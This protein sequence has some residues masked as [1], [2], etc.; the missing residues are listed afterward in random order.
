M[1]W[2]FLPFIVTDR[3]LLPSHPYYHYEYENQRYAFDFIMLKNGQAF[4]GDSLI[5]ES[6][7]AFGGP[8]LAPCA[9]TVIRVENTNSDNLDEHRAARRQL[10]R[11]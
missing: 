5:N 1:V 4:A 10:R 2:V 7:F 6:Y 9:G 3:N 11:D 8:I